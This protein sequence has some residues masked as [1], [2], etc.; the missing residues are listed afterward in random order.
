MIVC[1]RLYGEKNDTGAIK[2]ATSETNKNKFERGKTDKFTVEA[3]DIGPLK[4]LKVWHDGKGFGAGWHLDKVL[5]TA[6]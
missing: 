4:K 3:I 2:L 6:V 5:L 1:R